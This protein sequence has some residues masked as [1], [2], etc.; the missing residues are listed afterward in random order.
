MAGGNASHNPESG[1]STMPATAINHRAFHLFIPRP[2]SDQ[3]HMGREIRRLTG[4]SPG[5]LNQLMATHETFWFY[6]LLD[7]F[8]W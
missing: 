1:I 8:L 4:L 7:K 6:R 2:L 5:K 3:S